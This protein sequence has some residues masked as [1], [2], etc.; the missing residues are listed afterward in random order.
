[1]TDY[2]PFDNPK[3][4]ARAQKAV[5]ERDAD[6]HAM[7]LAGIEEGRTQERI[8]QEREAKRTEQRPTNKTREPR[9]RAQKAPDP[10][11]KARRL[12]SLAR[13]ARGR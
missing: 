3:E 13:K 6:R 10:F 9:Q 1:M 12:K 4:L 7:F 8:I 11:A 5:G 2:D